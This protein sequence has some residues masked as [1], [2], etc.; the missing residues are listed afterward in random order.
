MT[1][2]L[3][4]KQ[5]MYGHTT[6]FHLYDY[7]LPPAPPY[8]LRRMEGQCSGEVHCVQYCRPKN[9]PSFIIAL[10]YLGEHAVAF[11]AFCDSIA[12]SRKGYEIDLYPRGVFRHL[13]ARRRANIL[14][15]AGRMLFRNVGRVPPLRARASIE[16]GRFA[17]EIFAAWS[18]PEVGGQ[19]RYLVR[20]AI[21]PEELAEAL[22]DPNASTQT[23]LGDT[24]VMN[25]NIAPDHVLLPL[26]EQLPP[27][28]SITPAIYGSEQRPINVTGRAILVRTHDR[29]PVFWVY[30]SRTIDTA[31]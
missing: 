27:R 22:A 15:V 16:N 12:R 9:Y 14:R 3:C 7:D 20:H 25:V 11:S 26:Q 19:V 1:E 6:D 30:E 4:A 5:E 24:V 18:N 29:R 17:E 8:Y 31:V 21:T 23:G 2:R 28:W 13:G 10:P